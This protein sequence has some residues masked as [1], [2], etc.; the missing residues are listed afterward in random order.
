MP[1]DAIEEIIQESLYDFPYH[2]IPHFIQ[3]S[4]PSLS[5]RLSWGLDYL[6]Y[7]AHL[8]EMVS[9]T[10]PQSVLEVGCGDGC[11]IGHLPD[12]IPIRE[13][14]DLSTRAIQFAKAFN[15]QCTYHDCDISLLKAQYDIVVAIEVLEH[16]PDDQI[17]SFIKA[18]YERM[19]PHGKMI[20]SVPT[21][22]LPLNKKHFRHYTIE[23]LKKQ[24]SETALPL[25]IESYQ[26]IYK[27]SLLTTLLTRLHGNRWFSLEI[28]IFNQWVWKRVWNHHRI[29]DASN[30]YHLVAIIGRE[31]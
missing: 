14:C 12:I 27:N 18:M 23:L 10:K 9:E 15:P 5:R 29:A 22:V 25:N 26:Y 24:M 4:T 30:G 8:V 31:Q 20:I 3:N 16:I 17:S 13:G 21:T 6:C 11:F 2:Y 19:Q 7:Q 1:D 28:P